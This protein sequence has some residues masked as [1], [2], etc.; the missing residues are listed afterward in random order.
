ME[1]LMGIIAYPLS[2]EHVNLMLCLEQSNVE[3]LGLTVGWCPC[4]SWVS[5]SPA[6]CMAWMWLHPRISLPCTA[7]P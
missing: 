7:N 3:R 4:D 6:G 2:R 5:S 1:S